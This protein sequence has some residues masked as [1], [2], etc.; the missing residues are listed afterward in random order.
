MSPFEALYRRKCTTLIS[1]DNLVERLMMGP[2]ILQKIEKMVNMV[3]QNLK[4]AQDQQKSYT[5]L[6][7]RH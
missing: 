6:R 2:E 7:R 3:Q 4:E 1:W 5:D